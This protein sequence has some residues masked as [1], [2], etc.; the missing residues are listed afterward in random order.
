MYWVASTLHTTSDHGVYSI[1]TN[2]KT[3]AHISAASSR[4]DW[5]PRRFKWT[6]P[7][8]V[9]ARV[10]SYFN[11]PIPFTSAPCFFFIFRLLVL[12]A[13]LSKLFRNQEH[14]AKVL[15]FCVCSQNFNIKCIES[16]FVG[17]MLSC[18]GLLCDIL[19]DCDWLSEQ[20]EHRQGGYIGTWLYL[21]NAGSLFIVFKTTI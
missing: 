18:Y 6:R 19:L 10:P 7:R 20:V 15:F 9:S 12:R 4:L 2:N 3:D 17:R 11:W 1:T 16:M 13:N 14:E 8:L 5:R 21:S